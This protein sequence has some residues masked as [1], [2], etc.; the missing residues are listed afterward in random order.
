MTPS[1]A[2]YGQPFDEAESAGSLLKEMLDDPEL[3][4]LT[5][6]VAWVRYRGLLRLKTDID[7]FRKRGG[8][9][10]AIL[11]INEG[12][13]TRPGLLGILRTSDDAY[14]FHDRGG[15]TFHPKIYLG[16]GDEKA[17][18]LVGSSNLTPGGLFINVEASTSTL[19]ELP[20]ES[21][22]PALLAAQQFIARLIEDEDA[23][24]PLT[25]STLKSLL[26]DARYRIA[27]HERNRP[28]SSARLPGADPEDIDETG[29]IDDSSEEP[30]L[31]SRSRRTRA[32]IPPLTQADRE[33][34]ASLE[35]ADPEELTPAAPRRAQ[36]M[37][38]P[39]ERADEPSQ[40]GSST[41]L[42]TD[43]FWTKEM[44]PSDAQQG[45]GSATTKPTGLL[46]L[47]QESHEIDPQTWF[48]R[49]LFRTPVAWRNSIDRRGNPIEVAEVEFEVH[50][51]GVTRGTFVLKVDHAPHREA[52][53]R[54][55]PTILHWG[56]DLGKELRRTDYSG[57]ML[58]VERLDGG[59]YLLTID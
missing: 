17:V 53:Q 36:D 38:P 50:I 34:L 27:G 39:P 41:T 2:F 23:C 28:R 45:S 7:A 54:N 8:T 1:I 22:H 10:R 19:F 18:L 40:S 21:K 15:G 49:T 9:V 59:R 3:S 24:K 52:L 35:I 58:T 26:K 51:K 57:Q 55:I 30:Q 56:S 11:G 5:I 42:T 12:G 46:R 14:I 20:D 25:E 6:V 4:S 32:V 16:E 13:A 43:D 48:R 31:F 47:T 44:S 29:S 33:E 37:T